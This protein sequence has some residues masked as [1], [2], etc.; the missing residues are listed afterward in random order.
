[1][2]KRQVQDD[3]RRLAPAEGS[4]LLAAFA[5]TQGRAHASW[6]V[7]G[8]LGIVST[9]ILLARTGPS[10]LAFGFVALAVVSFSMVAAHRALT[11]ER[12]AAYA[13]FRS[14]P[15]PRE[16]FRVQLSDRR[17]N[18]VT[19]QLVRLRQLGLLEDSHRATLRVMHAAKQLAGR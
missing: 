9:C 17:D 8:G 3:A 10:W 14:C 5:R 13:L 11:P 18:L 6:L 19:R 12:V 15:L 16:E 7:L 2:Y 1:M 4:A